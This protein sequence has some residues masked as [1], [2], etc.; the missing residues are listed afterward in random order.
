MRTVA[1]DLG[2]RRIDFCEIGE[3]GV[4][5]HKTVKRLDQLRSELGPNKTPARVVFEACREGWHVAKVLKSWGHTPVMADTTRSKELGIGRHGRKNDRID[6]ERLAIALKENRIPKAYILSE[7][8]QELRFQISVRRLLV[9]TRA[10]YVASIRELVRARGDRIAGCGTR[11]FLEKLSEVALDDATK[12]LVRPLRDS[13]AILE[14][15]IGEVDQKIDQLCDGDPVIQRLMTAPGVALVVATAF[16]SVVDDAARFERAHQL[17]S[18]LGLVP[19]EDSSGGKRKLGSISKAGNSYA[20]AM[21]VQAAWCILR[22]GSEDPLTAWG[23]HVAAR[24]G[25]K[26]AVV[27]VAR[28]LAGILWAMWRT[29]TCYDPERLG[30]SSSQGLE[31]QADQ[32]HRNAEQL[33]R[34]AA[35]LARRRRL[36]RNALQK[37]RAQS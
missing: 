32:I 9:E 30:R 6:V 12:L 11:D 26:I 7:R 23:Q 8:S 35:K 22:R 20:R 29:E 10:Q 2:A 34:A 18:Y 36:V 3:G 24:R 37:V 16:L 15:Q 14:Q 13:L 19:S 25:K 21:L 17:E 28:R 31:Q 27:A 1:L 5:L 33:K 4:L